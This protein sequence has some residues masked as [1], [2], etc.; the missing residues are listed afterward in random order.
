MERPA[1]PPSP[2][3]RRHALALLAGAGLVTL[4]ACSSDSGSGA[5]AA[6][7]STSS[8]TTSTGGAGGAAPAAARIP[9][10]MAGPY[11]ADGTNGP[12]ALRTQGVVREDIRSSFA[13][14]PGVAPGVPLRLDLTVLRGA[15]VLTGAAVY[16]W[17]C[18]AA[19]LYSMYSEGATEQNYLRGVQP[20]DRDGR[21]RFTTIFPGAYPGRWPH[22]HFEVYEDVAAATGGGTPLLTSQL[23]LP[24]D[25]C[26]SVYASGDDYS[27]SRRV[28]PQTTL[29]SDGIFNDGWSHQVATVS[30]QAGSGMTA[31][32]R[33]SI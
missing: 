23:A 3:T 33:F 19:G 26:R 27:E 21:V 32:L 29:Q 24:D 12:D 28:F 1:E 7:T 4:A 20:T 31:S 16:A 13:G 18:D 5:R 8:T 14:A 11:P 10:E 6:S 17:Q 22:V 15:A 25:A 9:E 30:G 2:V